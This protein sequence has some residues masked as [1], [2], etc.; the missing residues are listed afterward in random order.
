VEVVA[1]AGIGLISLAVG[2][3]LETMAA[4]ICQI[5]VLVVVEVVHHL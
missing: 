5:L 2:F 4:D 3:L 1:V